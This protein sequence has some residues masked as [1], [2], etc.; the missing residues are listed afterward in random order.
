MPDPIIWNGMTQ[1]GLDAAYNNMAAVADSTERLAA[2]TDRSNHLRQRQSGELEIPYGPHQRNRF[3]IF[4]SGSLSAPLVV[5]IHGGWWQRNSKEV[6]SCV[7][8]GPMSHGLDV[9]LVGYTLAP[10][11]TLRQIAQ[12][13]STG[14]DA[15]ASYQIVRGGTPRFILVGWSAGG[16][17]TALTMEHP[18]VAAGLSISG[19]FDL[20]PIRL[21]Y[22]NDKLCLAAGDV[23]DLSPAHGIP[24]GKPLTI[25]YGL[26]ELPEM[27]RQSLDYAAHADRHGK[28]VTC[29]P[30]AGNDH[31]SIIEELASPKGRLA[32]ACAELAG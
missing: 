2:W 5:F 6:F 24:T 20:E 1:A 15:I 9:A 23:S 8:E 7:A 17:L 22:I 27:Q 10:E 13:V 18:A 14:L 32:R 3:D 19:V 16:H 31:F 12:Q 26:A 25:A 11:A 28:P 21:S 30:Q 4:R 29:L